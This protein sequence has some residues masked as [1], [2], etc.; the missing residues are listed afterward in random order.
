MCLKGFIFCILLH[1]IT[2][3][4]FNI[5]III[6]STKIGCGHLSLYPKV[7]RPRDVSLA[8]HLGTIGSLS[9]QSL[10]NRTTSRTSVFYVVEAVPWDQKARTKSYRTD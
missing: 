7:H 8:L 4:V 9:K 3:C 5:K 2:M 1:G 10:L 6:F